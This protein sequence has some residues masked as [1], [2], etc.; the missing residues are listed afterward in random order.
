MEMSKVRAN[1]IDKLQFLQFFSGVASCC[2]VALPGPEESCLTPPPEHSSANCKSRKFLPN[3]HSCANFCAD[4]S[5]NGTS[6]SDCKRLRQFG[7]EK[8][9]R[10]S[11]SCMSSNSNLYPG[12]LNIQ[13]VSL[14]SSNPKVEEERE[15]G[16]QS[17]VKDTEMELVAFLVL[18]NVRNE[19]DAKEQ[20]ILQMKVL[21]P[22]AVMPCVVVVNHIP[23]LASGGK[24]D[25]RTLLDEFAEKQKDED[26]LHWANLLQERIVFWK[27]RSK[28]S[29]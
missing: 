27:V 6:T 1:F 23:I 20:I 4:N 18:K 3:R 29:F 28:V 8:I 16:F 24:I 15:S 25:K 10:K 5:A 14:S 7:A 22:K 9:R 12:T 17:N 26:G 19:D 21:L 13:T 11:T 2:V